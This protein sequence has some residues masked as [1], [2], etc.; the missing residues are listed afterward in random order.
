MDLFEEIM[1]DEFWKKPD[2][3][4]FSNAKDL[5]AVRWPGFVRQPEL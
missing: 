4:R 5:F 2:Y 1:S 3:V